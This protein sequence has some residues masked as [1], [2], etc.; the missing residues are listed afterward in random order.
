[1]PPH[2]RS[3]RARL[4]LLGLLCALSFVLYID[5]VCIAQA[6]EPIQQELKL[7]N[8]QVGY[9]LMAFTLAYGL[10]ELPAGRWGDRAGSRAILTRI[11]LW[12]SAFTALTA[13]C[14]GFYSLLVARFL[15]GAG[16]AGAYPNAARIVS[17]WYP[18]AE[19]GRVQGLIQT[20]ALVGGTAAPVAAA[21]L[22][23]A[24]GWRWAF[25]LF[26]AL[27]VAWAAVFW[28]WFRD[29]PARHPA[30]NAGELALLGERL[31]DAKGHG[32]IPWGLV[33][34]NRS[35][36]T[37]GLI[38]ICGAFN[39]YLYFSWFPKY[40]Q[41]ARE[42]DPVEAGWLASLVMGGAAVGTLSG[43]FLDD[44][45]R[46][47]RARHG[48]RW[49]GASAYSLAA[50]LIGMGLLCESP[51]ALAVCAGLSC[52]AAMCPMSAWWSCAIEVSGRH[53]GALFGLMNGMGVFGAM[54]SQF[55]FGAFADWRKAQG[56]DGRAQ[57]DPAFAVYIAALLAAALCWA[58]YVSC[59]VEP[60]R[61]ETHTG[62]DAARNP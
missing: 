19:R 23:R 55:F 32:A 35:I 9:V 14:T 49:L 51:R 42:L 4:T 20:A 31:A 48:R 25:V 12:W 21:Y 52:L 41:E 29:D 57:W 17:R 61:H 45:L 43:G 37:L 36:W 58:F 50:G 22:I 8:T 56:Y 54:G 62:T 18:A 47:N 6:V 10:F 38:I 15:F 7:S 59:P 26:G 46:R 11:A 40:L 27:G 16:E 3:S 33:L 28:L 13:A 44:L 1:M 60:D 39:S 2:P 24:L 5:R 30:V 53:L 34:T